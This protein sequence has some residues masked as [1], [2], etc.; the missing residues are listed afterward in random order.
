MLHAN[1]FFFM[2]YTERNFE[3]KYK[4]SYHGP[5]YGLNYASSISRYMLSLTW[6]PV[7]FLLKEIIQTISPKY[8]PRTIKYDTEIGLLKCYNALHRV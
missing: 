6:N 3:T 4:S 8:Y 7:F 1:V 5:K 2:F